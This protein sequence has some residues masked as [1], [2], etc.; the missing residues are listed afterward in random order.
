MKFLPNG[1]TTIAFLAASIA[2]AFTH[3]H[4]LALAALSAAA[5]HAAQTRLAPNV[6]LT[7]IAA[8][9]TAS[10]FHLVV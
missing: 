4:D 3:Q 7:I 2:F 1:V 9:I 6:P 8:G 10:I 5:G